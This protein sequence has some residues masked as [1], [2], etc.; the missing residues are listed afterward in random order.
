M[1]VVFDWITDNWDKIVALVDK[2]IS[3]LMEIID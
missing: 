3:L 2:C 1:E